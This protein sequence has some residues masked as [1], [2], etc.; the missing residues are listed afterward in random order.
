LTAPGVA[1]TRMAGKCIVIM[2]SQRAKYALKALVALARAWPGE[3]LLISEIAESCSIPRKFL[4]QI[5]LELKRDGLVQSRRGKLGGYQLRKA[6]A[7]ISFGRVLRVIDGPIALLPCLS[8]IAYR[9]CQD[10]PSEAKCDI[11]RA[12]ADVADTSRQILDSTSLDDAL[13][14]KTYLGSS[15]STLRKARSRVFPAAH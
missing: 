2:I 14:K 5:L 9:R 15:K 3:T 11:R 10:C 1:V 6:P 13:R 4:E 7:E 8:K 12:F